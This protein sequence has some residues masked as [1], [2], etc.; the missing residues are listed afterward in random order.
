LQLMALRHFG[1]SRS[2]QLFGA[3]SAFTLAVE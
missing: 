3:S 2:Y 1:S